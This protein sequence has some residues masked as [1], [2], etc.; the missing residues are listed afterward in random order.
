MEV[1]F[2]WIRVII[3]LG[4]TKP[5]CSL[6]LPLQIHRKPSSN[7]L[8]LKRG[9]IAMKQ[10][11]QFVPALGT[12]STFL[13]ALGHLLK[14]ADTRTKV[15]A[16]SFTWR[17]KRKPFLR[18]KVLNIAQIDFWANLSGWGCHV[19]AAPALPWTNFQGR[20]DEITSLDAQ[21]RIHSWTGDGITFTPNSCL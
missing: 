13:C 5:Q 17:R 4:V 20:E 19:P 21:I 3:I 11:S 10:E 16:A 12:M 1:Q 15:S 14:I 7:W 8:K 6:M 9:F 18:S 2:N